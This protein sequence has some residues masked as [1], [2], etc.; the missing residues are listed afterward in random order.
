MP[1]AG[2]VSLRFR[3]RSAVLEAFQM[4]EERR[5]NQGDWPGWMRRAWKLDHGTLGALYPADVPSGAWTG[6]LTL[7]ALGGDYFVELGDWIVRD[8][9]GALSSYDNDDFEATYEEVE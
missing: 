1:G 2:T 8:A 7:R 9:D 6:A 5:L 3:R 4:T